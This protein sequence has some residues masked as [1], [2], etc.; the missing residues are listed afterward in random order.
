MSGVKRVEFRKVRCRKGTDL[1]V[2]YA[3]RP[4][5]K[6]LG[7]FEVSF[8]Q[9]A[10]PDE[11]WKRFGN[12]GGISRS[13]YVQYYAGKT[14][15]VAIGIGRVHRIRPERPLRRLGNGISPPQSYQYL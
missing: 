1:A 8:V 13:E 14:I 10:T 5:Q 15:G 2:V 12:V 11:L 9:E 3:T 7:Y 6:L 4:I